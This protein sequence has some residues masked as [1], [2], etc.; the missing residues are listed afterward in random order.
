MEFFINQNSTLPK[1]TLFVVKDGRNDYHHFM[2]TISSSTIYFSM[3]DVD[4]GFL[5]IVKK[6]VQVLLVELSEPQEYYLE[7]QFNYHDTKKIGRYEGE[8]MISNDEGDIAWVES[9]M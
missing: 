1:L 8:F 6:P 4:T 9:Q 5:K 7:F 3:K 2:Q